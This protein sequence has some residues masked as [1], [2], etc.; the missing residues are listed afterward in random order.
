MPLILGLQ[1][2]APRWHRWELGQHGDSLTDV[3]PRSRCHATP[4]VGRLREA[5]TTS[6]PFETVPRGL[7][8]FPLSLMKPHQAA[9]PCYKYLCDIFLHV[10]STNVR[11]IIQPTEDI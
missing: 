7:S 3:R 6:V 11:L 5:P 2:R 4:M 8:L 1:D 10:L 9:L